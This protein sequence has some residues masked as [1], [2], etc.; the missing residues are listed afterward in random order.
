MFARSP[1][2]ASL[3]GLCCK[4]VWIKQHQLHFLHLS[5]LFVITA[6]KWDRKKETSHESLYFLFGRNFKLTLGNFVKFPVFKGGILTMEEA[7]SSSDTFLVETTAV[8]WL[9]T[10]EK[11]IT[12]LADEVMFY[13]KLF[14]CI[15]GLFGNLMNIVVIQYSEVPMTTRITISILAISDFCYIALLSPSIVYPKVYKLSFFDIS[16]TICQYTTFSSLFFAFVSGLMVVVLTVERVIAV[17]LPLQVKLLLSVK[18]LLVGISLFVLV[19]MGI[20]AYFAS[21]LTVKGYYDSNNTLIYSACFPDE[22]KDELHYFGVINMIIPLVLVVLGNIIII[23][24]VL[25]KKKQISRMTSSGGFQAI[26]I[27]LVVTTVSISLSSIILTLPA[28]LHFSVGEAIV[29]HEVYVDWT[30]P[31]YLTIDAIVMLR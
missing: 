15:I 27:R 18:K 31:L 21:E 28:A 11:D 19:H 6:R 24:T 9:Q 23:A 22:L 17:T 25:V 3:L 29:G 5:L 16:N 13:Y 30:N 10:E 14:V 1:A 26:D 2:P 4:C 20:S 8:S 7:A 12:S